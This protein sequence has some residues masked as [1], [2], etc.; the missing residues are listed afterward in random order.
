MTVTVSR[1]TFSRLATW[2]I[3]GPRQLLRSALM[4]PQRNEGGPNAT[5]DHSESPQDLRTLVWRNTVQYERDDDDRRDRPQLGRVGR[6]T[7]LQPHQALP[8]ST[9]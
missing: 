6:E 7:E 4:S 3:T 5:N 1:S 2:I 8:S 9:G